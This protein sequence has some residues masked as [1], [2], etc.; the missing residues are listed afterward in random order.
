MSPT[1]NTSSFAEWSKP[2]KRKG[3]FSF[4]AIYHVRGLI[5][6][7]L[8]G[9]I[10]A[11]EI[12]APRSG[13]RK[14]LTAPSGNTT[15]CENQP[16]RCLSFGVAAPLTTDGSP[17]QPT[18]KHCHQ[19][20]LSVASPPAQ[21]PQPQSPLEGHLPPGPRKTARPPP[22]PPAPKPTHSFAPTEDAESFFWHSTPFSMNMPTFRHGRIRIRKPY[23][24]G[25]IREGT[26]F[27]VATLGGADD[28][29]SDSPYFSRHTDDERD[30]ILAWFAD[31]GFESEGRLVRTRHSA[32]ARSKVHSHVR[33]IS[34][35][36]SSALPSH[37][38]LPS[39]P[40]RSGHRCQIKM[41]EGWR[42]QDSA[43]SPPQSPMADLRFM[44]DGADGD[45][46]VMGFNLGHDCKG[47]L[48]WASEQGSHT[49]WM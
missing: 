8:L 41:S 48:E 43:E 24:L 45:F 34:S 22:L 44:G 15:S 17:L 36:S 23:C 47:Y 27:Q 28:S 13:K 7:Y 29:S 18:P 31:F 9:E 3:V 26:S 19:P 21:P 37:E 38:W 14:P 12:V 6:W 25:D 16:R 33:A 20:T 32:P 39:T 42:A 30:D 11:D 35:A 49:R 1:H 46:V 2:P 5:R 4:R 10:E 40:S